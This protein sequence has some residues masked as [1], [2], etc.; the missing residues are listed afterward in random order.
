MGL[1]CNSDGDHKCSQPV[2]ERDTSPE[3][4]PVLTGGKNHQMFAFL[5]KTNP[6]TCG[7]SSSSLED[8]E[9][10]MRISAIEGDGFQ[11][12]DLTGDK[13]LKFREGRPDVRAYD[14][15]FYEVESAV[16]QLTEEERMSMKIRPDQ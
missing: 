8:A 9:G 6:K 3:F 16:G 7:I 15:C 1:H 13:A 14:S 11:K 4:M 10:S 5:P 12:I 2:D